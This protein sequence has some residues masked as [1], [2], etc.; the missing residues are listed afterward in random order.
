[1]ARAEELEAELQSL[2]ERARALEKELA[3]LRAPP[4]GESPAAAE[5]PLWQSEE[6][7]FSRWLI[8]SSVDG[9]LA[10]DTGLRY[11]L[12]N[13]AME[14]ISGV[15]KADVLGR[16]AVEVFPFL[17][18]IGEDQFFHEALAGKRPVSRNRPYIVPATGRQG[19]F[20]GFYSPLRDPRGEVIGGLCIVRDITEQKQLEKKI[21]HAQKLET[22]GVLAGGIAHDFNNLLMVILGNAE[23]GLM[24]AEPGSLTR[25]TLEQIQTAALRA[26]ELCRQMLA[27]SGKSR[28]STNPLDLSTLVREIGE[29]LRVSVSKKAAIEYDLGDDLPPVEAD[30]TQLRQVVMNLITN[31]SDALGDAAGTI[32]LRT[33]ALV[34]DRPYLDSTYADGE[35]PEGLYVFLDVVDDGHGMDDDTVNRI[36]DPFFST[37]TKG[38]GLGMAAVWGI[39][40]GHQ[41]ALRV[42]SK[43][44]HGTAVRVLF[45]PSVT[46]LREYG[47]LADDL[48]GWRGIGKILVV[49][50]EEMVR[51]VAASI[52][53]NFGFDTLTAAEGRAAIEVFRQNADEIVLVLLDMTMPHMTGEEVLAELHAIRPDLPVLLAS[54]Y[55]EADAAERCQSGSGG[56]AGF[57]QKPYRAAQLG[58]R[59]RALL[60]KSQTVMDQEPA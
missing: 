4:A 52:I 3:A 34:A 43:R 41:G 56:C 24:Q 46:A 47:G 27:Y 45:P 42:D 54:G 7:E 17:K 19:I 23:I 8:E 48:H 18:D 40:R 26:A 9:I 10:F 28:L 11:T 33:G 22:L 20:E 1:V 29:L 58:A 12:W 35:L 2:T 39:V 15:P 44:G 57:I 32:T 37:K 6:S 38:R 53:E 16:V 50:D 60:G 59:L 49:D 21:Q 14:R 30:A 51:V 5:T 13:P 31:A 55:T 25:S 36:F